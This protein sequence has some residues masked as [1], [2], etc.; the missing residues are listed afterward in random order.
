M[1]EKISKE[2]TIYEL[3]SSFPDYKEEIAR[4]LYDNGMRCIGCPSAAFESIEDGLLAHGKSE[5]E[6]TS[7]IKQLNQIIKT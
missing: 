2:M 1:N 6:I 7:L 4:A 5:E 3:V